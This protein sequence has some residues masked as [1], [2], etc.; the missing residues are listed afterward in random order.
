MERMTRSRVSE[1]CTHG[2][3]GTW[4]AIIE[5]GSRKLEC[6]SARSMKCV[7]FHSR[8]RVPPIPSTV[9]ADIDEVL[10]SAVAPASCQPE[11]TTTPEFC[12]IRS[13]STMAV[14]QR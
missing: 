11:T 8:S 6:S 10:G 2:T 4:S 14:L 9:T 7:L 12:N 1:T 5:T 13:T 3:S